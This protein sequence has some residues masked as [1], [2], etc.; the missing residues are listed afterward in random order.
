MTPQPCMLLASGSLEFIYHAPR[1]VAR[2]VPDKLPPLGCSGGSCYPSTSNLIIG[3]G[4]VL[5]TSSTCGL[6]GP[7]LYCIVS[8]LQIGRRDAENCFFC[9]S[10]DWKSHGIENVI[11]QSGPGGKKT[12]WQAERDILAL[13]LER[14]VDHGHFWHMYRYFAHNCLGLFPG[15]SLSPGHRV[16]DLISA[17]A[18][19]MPLSA[20]LHPGSHT[21]WKA[22]CM[23]FVS[24]A[25]TELVPTER[26]QDLHQDHPWQAAEPGHPH[27]YQASP[28]HSHLPCSAP[29]CECH[30][31]ARSCHFDVALYLASGNVSGVSMV[32]SDLTLSALLTPDL[33][34]DCNPLGALEGGLCDAHTDETSGLLSGQYRCKVHVWGQRCDSSGL[35]A[36]A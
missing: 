23:A 6:H 10:R 7:E 1:T 24:P 11:S 12:W 21:T 36:M 25:T 34:C 33:A 35:V 17:C 14:S 8:N 29:E 18:M 15:I 9:D 13:L 19:A 16:S 20:G 4:Q 22:W 27:A 2:E 3:C 30:G 31:H 26:C 28:L 5:R 32:T